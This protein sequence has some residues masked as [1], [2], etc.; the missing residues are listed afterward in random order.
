MLGWKSGDVA[1][2]SANICNEKVSM[3]S[4]RKKL[5]STDPLVFLR[6]CISTRRLDML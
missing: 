6:Q 1:F 5:Y 4:L 3:V 2:N